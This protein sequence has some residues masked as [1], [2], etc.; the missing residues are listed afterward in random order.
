MSRFTIAACQVC[1]GDDRAKNLA[2]ATRLVR[3]AAD[4]GAEVVC[5]PEMWPFVGRD[6]DKIAG[7]ETLDGPSMTAMK[8]LARDLGLWLFPG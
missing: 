1:A 8:R 6:A 3:E 4:R 7:A 2:T 5:L